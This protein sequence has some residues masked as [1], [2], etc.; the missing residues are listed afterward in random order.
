MFQVRAKRGFCSVT[1]TAPTLRSQSRLRAFTLI[2]LL[3]VIAIIAILIGLLLPA[4][5]KVREAAARMRC[6]NHLK[7][8]GI[9]LHSYHDTN[10]YM[11]GGGFSPWEQHGSWPIQ[12]LPQIEQDNLARLNPQ[13]NNANVLRTHGV[14]IFVCPSR[15]TNGFLSTGNY[16]IDYAAATPANA[17]GSWDQFWHGDIWGGYSGTWSS[18]AYR[19]VIARGGLWTPTGRWYGSKVTMT[20]ISD[21]TTNTLLLSEKQLNPQAYVNGDWHDDAGWADG[22]DPD[23]IRYTGFTPNPDSRYNNQGGWEGY[24]FGGVHSGGI[25]SLMADGSVRFINYNVDPNTFNAIG[26]RNGGEVTPNF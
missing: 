20:S 6:G 4:V 5:Q 16:T 2:E 10:S 14:A 18:G 21:G 23:V 7:Q 26:T 13:N 1:H 22:W 3:V 12:I 24:R 8:L 19:G 11:P 17:P 9:A 25:N 15:R